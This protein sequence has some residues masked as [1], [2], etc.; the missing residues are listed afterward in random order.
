MYIKE[1]PKINETSH[2]IV[3]W[4]VNVVSDTASESVIVDIF[5]VEVH[6]VWYIV[7]FIPRY[8]NEARYV[9]ILQAGTFVTMQ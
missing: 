9:G 6:L 4:F 2:K 7:A 3:L 1:E 5:V 8:S